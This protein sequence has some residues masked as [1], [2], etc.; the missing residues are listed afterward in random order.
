M[1]RLGIFGGTFDPIHCGHVFLAQ[2]IAEE[3][4]LDEVLFIPAAAPPLKE[5]SVER[6]AAEDRWAMVELAIA[7]LDGF[8]GSR[9]ELERPGKSY[10]FDTLQALRAQNPGSEFYLIIGADNVAQL[11]S[12]HKPEGILALCT[13]VVGTR[14]TEGVE[15]DAGLVERIVTVDTPVVQLSSTEI[16]RRV[17]EGKSIR[18]MV[19]EG[20]EAYIREKG[21]YL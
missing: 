1:R 18:Y 14:V 3:L 15:L 21:L 20:V 17:V 12:W 4:A 16:R 5:D 11:H 8:K 7:G 9:I 10:T 13:I 2:F 19:P 6:A